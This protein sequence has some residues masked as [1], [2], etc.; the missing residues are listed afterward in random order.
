[1]TVIGVFLLFG[2]IVACLAGTTLVEPG[3]VLDRMWVLNPRAYSE[4]APLGRT[5]GLGF[6]LLAVA[7]AAAG[8]GWSHRRRWGWQ[9]AVAIFATQ[10]VGDFVH[11]LTGHVWQGAVGV[12]IA[13]AILAYITRPNV[14]NAFS[15]R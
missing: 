5:V 9:L 4:L 1:M 2:A 14:R 12:T 3:T 10:V 15:V 11:V 8:F 6:L 13:G 7:L